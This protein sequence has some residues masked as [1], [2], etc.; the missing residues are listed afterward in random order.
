VVPP[1]PMYALSLIFEGPGAQWH[2]LSTIF[3][4]SG[5]IGIGGF[6]YVVLFGTVVGSS[7]WTTLMRRNPAGIVAP[8]SLL[9]P[10]V[11]MT[12][13][14]LLLGER[15]AVVEI[16]AGIVIIFGVLLG[17]LPRRQRSTEAVSE[18]AGVVV[19]SSP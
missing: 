11:G 14:F 7:I 12:A 18:E 8:F 5:A 2:S 15:P 1:L 4:H 3:T 13:S 6:A 17:S 16:A 19:P 9:V 10:V